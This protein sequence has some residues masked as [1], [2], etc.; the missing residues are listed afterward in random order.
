MIYLFFV[1]RGHTKVQIMCK[2]LK[3]FY[4]ISYSKALQWSPQE[5]FHTYRQHNQYL[6]IPIEE[7]NGIF[8][9]I[10]EGAQLEL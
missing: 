10:A 5:K 9:I 2:T 1:N 4:E 8:G 6:T 7:D 3:Y